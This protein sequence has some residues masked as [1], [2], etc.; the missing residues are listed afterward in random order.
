MKI[1]QQ[2]RIIILIL[3]FI[4][5]FASCQNRDKQVDIT[6]LY[7]NDY[8]LF[9]QTKAWELAKAVDDQDLTLI[10]EIL[11]I[12][13]IDINIIEPIFG[14]TLLFLTISN[15][16]FKSFKRLIELGIDINIHNTMDSSSAIHFVCKYHGIYDNYTE[17][18][19][20]LINND[21]DV[22]DKLRI[23]DG[24][25]QL[26]STPL[27]IICTSPPEYGPNLQIAKLLIN[28]GADINYTDS[29]YNFPLSNS[30]SGSNYDIALY[31]IKKGAKYKIPMQKPDIYTDS[32]IYIMEKLSYCFERLGSKEY[33]D[34]MEL[35]DFLESKGLEYKRI[36]DYSLPVIQNVKNLYPNNW[37]EYLKVY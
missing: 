19:K 17:Y 13:T 23:K 9:Q 2:N 18:L 14:Q 30:I 37:E 25:G 21:A 1:L 7:N 15:N 27:M 20:I 22:N 34:K 32:N 24:Y 31:L 33:K 16:D 4:P 12:D 11:S 36:T 35:I 29:V 6:K 28:N 10:E 26:G 8:R 3:F 5:F